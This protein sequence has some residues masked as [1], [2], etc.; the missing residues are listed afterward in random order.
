MSQSHGCS[1]RAGYC[2]ALGHSGLARATAYRS[3]WALC[4]L[5][6]LGLPTLSPAAPL[7]WSE[8]APTETALPALQQMNE[9]L[10]TL[11]QQLL[12]AVVSLK[13][14][15]KKDTQVALPKTHPPVPDD[16]E[17][18]VTGSG[19]LI[20]ADGL[21]LTNHHVIDD[22]TRIEVHLHDGTT[23]TA[24]VL[25]RDPA[26]DLALLQ[27][28]LERPLPVLP[29]G[30]SAALRVGEFVVAIGSP[31]GFEHTITF[32]I[33]SGKKRNFLRSGLVGGYVQTDAHITVGNSG[34]PLVNMRG[35]VV[36]INTAIA[37]RGEAGFAIPIDIVKDLLPQLYAAGRVVRGWLGVHIR[38]L[39]QVK[40]N[41][42][43]ADAAQGVYIHAVVPDQPAHQAG[44]VAGDVIVSFDGK[45]VATP[46]DLQS[47]VA[48][49][50]AGKKVKVGVLR[51]RTVRTVEVALGT[52]PERQETEERKRGER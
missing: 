40:G 48:G 4:C 42:A 35:E 1:A 17:P 37:G 13:V 52:M 19:F 8:R 39:D 26:G 33:I 27:I 25:G 49:T 23:T 2:R 41:P 51:A 10:V 43:A 18:S 7:L 46:A 36:G 47:A 11:T 24:T 6:V 3:V 20:R 16:D 15:T 29:L 30:N 14:N 5:S 45:A 9:E 31:F 12:P 34:G 21:V 28:A 22:S 44:I 50:P 32:G 38:A